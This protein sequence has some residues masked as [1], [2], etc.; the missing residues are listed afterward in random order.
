MYLKS[1]LSGKTAGNFVPIHDFPEAVQI[2]RTAVAVVD[3]V[4][5]FPYVAS[6][7]GGVVA[8]EG[9]SSVRGGYQI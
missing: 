7:Q 9:G 4:G 8:V 2:V 3:V 6:Q 1:S 5:M